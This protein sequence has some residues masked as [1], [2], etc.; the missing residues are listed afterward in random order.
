MERGKRSAQADSANYSIRPPFKDKFR[1]AEAKAVIERIIPDIVLKH[2][3]LQLSQSEAV[4]RREQLSKELSQQVNQALK[5]LK[6]D[7]R[8]KFVVQ[9][10]VGQTNGQG[11]RVASRC[12]W[13]ED[14]DDVAFVSFSND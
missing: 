2:S 11:F 5:D 13:D 14:T 8:Y 10:T 3:T 6:K 7:E 1:A 12:Y 4:D 9:V